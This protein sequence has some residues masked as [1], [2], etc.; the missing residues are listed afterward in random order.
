MK[1]GIVM[2]VKSDTIIMMTPEGE[3]IKTRKEPSVHYEIGEELTFLPQLEENKTTVL[4]RL[5]QKLHVKPV[6]S[7]AAAILMVL[8][9]LLPVLE[10]PEVYAYVSVDINPSFE[11]TINQDK[12]VIDIKPFNTEAE[13][14]LDEMPDL[15]G[16]S[17]IE[18]TEEIIDVST[19]NGYL[20]TQKKVVVTTVFTEEADNTD[21]E[22]IE[23]EIKQLSKE[24]LNKGTADI[25]VVETSIEAREEAIA[26]GVT[27]GQLLIQK[28][29][30]QKK[31]SMTKNPK[32]K[33]IPKEKPQASKKSVGT[34]QSKEV[35]A[36]EKQAAKQE[37]SLKS[38]GKPN[39]STNSGEKKDKQHN[40]KGNGKDTQDSEKKPSKE[41]HRGDGSSNGHEKDDKTHK[42]KFKEEKEETPQKDKDKNDKIKNEK[43]HKHSSGNKNEKEEKEDEEED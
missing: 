1:K 11:M 35:P 20:G 12:E 18:V 25:S 29:E 42:N 9:I 31:Q 37:N 19:K 38:N 33:S 4:Q 28:E 36:A 7:G 15:E 10:D 6:L 22:S 5:R 27:A 40:A 30:K 21:R 23:K 8:F 2:E 39:L 16:K 3:F 14:M 34:D 13:E 24:K 41:K 26:V 43:H 17:I 32:E